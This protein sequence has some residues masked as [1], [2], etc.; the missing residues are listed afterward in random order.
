MLDWSGCPLVEVRPEV[1]HGRPVLK[2]TRMPADDIVENWEAGIDEFEIAANFRLPVEQV[3]AIL[4][5]AANR[6]DAPHSVR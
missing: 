4:S 2:G 3:K 5:Y 1:Q 6:Q